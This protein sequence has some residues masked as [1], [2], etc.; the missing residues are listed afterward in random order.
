MPKLSMHEKE[1][2]L[3]SLGYSGG[4]YD[5][6]EDLFE[7][8]FISDNH[9]RYKVTYQNFKAEGMPVIFGWRAGFEKDAK[10]PI[11]IPDNKGTWI[12]E[13]GRVMQYRSTPHTR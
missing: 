12:H 8:R 13:Y 1:A 7:V 11:V 5:N 9:M 2:I 6:D 3:N 10:L 4:G